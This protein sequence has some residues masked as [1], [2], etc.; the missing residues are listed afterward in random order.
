[1]KDLLGWHTKNHL[2]C[3]N[4]HDK[5]FIKKK[6]KKKKEPQLSHFLRFW[7]VTAMYV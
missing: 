2:V 4:N 1:M 7:S 3:K 6:K 5:S